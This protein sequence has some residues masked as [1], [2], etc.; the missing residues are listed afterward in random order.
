MRPRPLLLALLLPLCAARGAEDWPSWSGPRGTLA[1]DSPPLVDD[2][3][4]ARPLWTSEPVPPP[5]TVHARDAKGDTRLLAGGGAASPVV[6]DGRVY[7]GFFLP[8]GKAVDAEQARKFK[9]KEGDDDTPARISADDAVLCLDAATGKTLWKRVFADQGFNWHG[10]RFGPWNH[11]PLVADGMVVF[12]GSTGRIHALDAGTGEPRWESDLGPFHT[13][14][15][16]HKRECL[17]KGRF[18]SAEFVYRER[19]GAPAWIGGRVVLPDY[20]GRESSGLLGLDAATGKP[21]WR[22]PGIT[23]F[24]VQPAAWRRGG[25]ELAVVA[26]VHGDVSL[27]DPRNGNLMWTY[28]D[29]GHNPRSIVVADD[30]ALLNFGPRPDSA[31]TRQAKPRKPSRLGALELLAGGAAERWQLPADL[32]PAGGNPV[33]VAHG[34]AFA[35]LPQDKCLVAVELATGRVTDRVET[36]GGEGALAVVGDR[37]LLEE[38]SA[39]AR[40]ELRMFG[41]RGGKLTPMGAPWPTPHPPS[42]SSVPPLAFTSAGGVLFFRGAGA[43]HAVDLRREPAP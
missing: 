24:N 20:T 33:A 18:Q 41:V 16:E 34:H 13:E 5:R 42:Y 21:A 12:V 3:A 15:E 8:S 31:S 35:H 6:A 25:A 23:A 29:A 14:L 39:K 1:V 32:G 11:T 2:L 30:L 43:V 40:S 26:S 22:V 28:S 4:R 19:A 38:Y 10:E 9:L 7:V 17:A 36:G 37:L 27:V